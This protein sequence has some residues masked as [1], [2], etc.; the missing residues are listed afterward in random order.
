MDTFAITLQIVGM[1]FFGWLVTLHEH[2]VYR[3]A[4][5][6]IYF[7]FLILSIRAT[8]TR[9]RRRNR[10]LILTGQLVDTQVRAYRA[11]ETAPPQD[12]RERHVNR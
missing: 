6:G 10:S 4:V 2:T 1:G 9:L 5:G 8:I 7:V 11:A 12:M 3:L